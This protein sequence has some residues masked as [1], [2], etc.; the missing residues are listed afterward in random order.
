MSECGTYLV[1]HIDKRLCVFPNEGTDC[2]TR[3]IT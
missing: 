1:H 3:I 2:V